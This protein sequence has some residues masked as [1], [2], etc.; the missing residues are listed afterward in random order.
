[1]GDALD[2]LY[3]DIANLKAL[4]NTQPN[5][6][7]DWKVVFNTAYNF[8]EGSMKGWGV[9]GGVRWESSDI[10]GYAFDV[11]SLN[12]PTRPVV[13]DSS[14]PFEGEDILDVSGWLSY[15]TTIN[16]VWMR[17]QL[18]VTNLL[19]EDGTFP[20]S[21]VDDLTGNP[22]YGRQQVREPRSFVFTTTFKF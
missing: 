21:A 14:K 20:R 3:T 13:V 9:G 1:V 17:F 22:Y 6:Q 10:V 12:D 8:R 11:D 5:A 18:N 19:D 16:G 2:S 15:T 4:V 7:R